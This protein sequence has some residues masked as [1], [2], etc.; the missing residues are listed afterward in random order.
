MVKLGEMLVEQAKITTRDLERTLVA[1]AEMGGLFGQ[2]LIKLGL[3]SELDVAQTKYDPLQIPLLS[4]A[5]YPEEPVNLPGLS[6]DFLL[7]NSVVPV[8]MNDGRAAFAAVL[9]LACARI[10]Q[11]LP[12]AL[13]PG[14]EDSASLQHR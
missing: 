13:W 9:S 14:G 3:V 7:S 4:A 8:S 10:A 5:D 6:M 12:P 2:V 11:R 1:Q